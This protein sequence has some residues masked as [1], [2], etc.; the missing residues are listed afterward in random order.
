MTKDR[1]PKISDGQSDM[2]HA[3]YEAIRQLMFH[4]EIVP[5][6]KISY[7][8]LSERLGMSTTPI[9]QA[10]KF[11]E[12]QNLVRHEPNRGYYTEPIDMH[13]VEEIYAAREL[14]EVS[15]LPETIRRIDQEAILKLQAAFKSYSAAASGKSFTRRLA[16]HKE[17][18]LT[19]ASLSGSRVQ[20]QILRSLFDLLYLKFGGSIVF[21]HYTRDN[22]NL[23]LHQHIS[24]AVVGRNLTRAQDL[25]RRDIRETREQVLSDLGQLIADKTTAVF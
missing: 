17:F 12:F 22:E 1:R 25:L 21:S 6:Q 23:L 4:N 10:L 9:I 8:D 15:L 3:A 18:H 11:L 5:G 13:E 20:I 14:I 24:E 16:L 7:R 19:L 2:T